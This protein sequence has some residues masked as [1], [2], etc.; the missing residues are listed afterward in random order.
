MIQD[1]SFGRAWIDSLP[2]HVLLV[3]AVRDSDGNVVDFIRRDFNRVA[4]ETLGFTRA[5]LFG[6]SILTVG[7]K[8]YGP[9]TLQRL[10]DCLDTD[11]PLLLNAIRYEIHA[12]PRYA[13][14][15]I[16]RA[17]TDLLA[18]SWRDVS[19]RVDATSRLAAAEEQY[20]L[21]AENS[22][23]VVAHVGGDGLVKWVSP[24]VESMLGA[25]PSHWIG[26]AAIDAVPQAE[27]A[28][29]E[30]INQRV[31]QGSTEL[32]RVRLFDAGGD[33]HWV[34]AHSK[35]FYDHGG[36]LDGY[37]V[38][39][40]LIDDR[41]SLEQERDTARRE[42]TDSD[43]RFRR[44]ME[45]SNVGMALATADGK[46]EM[47]N[48]AF[49]EQ[50]GYDQET[51]TTKSWQDLTPASYLEADLK[52]IA[53]LLAGRL[54]TYRLIKQHI[55]ADGHLVW[56]DLSVSCLRDTSGAVQY[57]F[58]Q[59]V[60][61][62][63]QVEAR[64]KQ[65]ESD[66]RFRRLMETSNVAMSLATL[67]GRLDVVNRAMCEL[68]GYDEETLRTKT[69]QEMT[70]SKYLET[71]VAKI[72]DLLVGRLDTYRVTKEMIRADGHPIWIDLSVSCL[73]D[74]AGAVEYFAAQCVDIT[75]EV[76]AREQL[77][78]QE[79]QTRLLAEQLADELSSAAQYV[80]SIL[81]G[82]LDGPV[83]VTS[84]YLPSQRLGGD[85]FDYRWLNDDHLMVYL[86]DVS[87]HGVD[88][89]LLSVS[90]HNL[91][92]SGTVPIESLLEPQEVLAELNQL[93]QMRSQGNKFFTMWYGVYQ[94][95]TRT[96]RYASAGHPPALAIVANGNAAAATT[97]STKCLPIGVMAD[98]EFVSETHQIPQ[99]SR[100]L[101]YSD[102]AY[103]L[104]DTHGQWWSL[105]DF[106][107][108]CT[109]CAAQES[110]SLDALVT[111]LQH[112]SADGN[113]L[114]DC[115]LIQLTFD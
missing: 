42:Q 86:L 28:N 9:A 74:A 66:A 110:C 100:L 46:F 21:L 38:F 88:A 36:E 62:T 94:K 73:R 23:D 16:A 4:H 14:V 92:R 45:T 53:D 104:I 109:E 65:A 60:D 114:D 22:V 106:I 61:I 59:I 8:F 7:P 72:D 15:R 77:A 78:L 52:N 54:D 3:E 80:T 63:E 103:E 43:A 39:L 79:S 102:G 6:T 82:E 93:F 20:R 101:I 18:I 11:Q 64:A 55:H 49:C 34:E 56:A 96:L 113:F 44:L 89:A 84:Q 32:H 115:A 107:D 81:P 91:L 105:E 83:R 48:E 30:A 29:A 108:V 1:L 111:R 2:E 41:V 47:I 19:D 27:R 75:A 70:P 69:W 10:I 68:L 33:A 58:G 31:L 95:S 50:L 17:G 12:H 87:G 13:D 57:L 99:G 85:S 76:E 40:R 5:E 67:E 25:P 112:H 35:P 97:L 37:I 71:D 90:V 26:S 24:S 98:A 51:L